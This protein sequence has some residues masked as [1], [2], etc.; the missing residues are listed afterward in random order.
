MAQD[1]EHL[2]INLD[3][4]DKDTSPKGSTLAHKSSTPKEENVTKKYNWKKILI[5]GGVIL[6]FGWVIFSDNNSSTSTTNTGS[7]TPPSINQASSNSDTVVIGEYRCSRYNYDK[8]VALA[9][10][11]NEQQIDTA[12]NA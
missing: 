1:K 3:F 11:E 7:Y 6:F 9:P 4:L 8:A 5:I 2:D 10:N 12:R